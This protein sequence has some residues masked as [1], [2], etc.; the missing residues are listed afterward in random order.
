MGYGKMNKFKTRSI[1]KN[2]QGSISLWFA[3]LGLIMISIVSTMSSRYLTKR[4]MNEIQGT[5]DVAGV[6]A[7][8]SGVDANA[9]RDGELVV[10]SSHVYATF[11]E[12]VSLDDLKAIVGADKISF[13]Q[14]IRTRKTTDY[15]DGKERSEVYLVTNTYLSI[16]GDVRFDTHAITNLRYFDFFDNTEKSITMKGTSGDGRK[17]IIVRSVSRLV[18]R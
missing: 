9:W 3:I 1:V 13:T 18:L 2:T 11:K 8:R 4:A 10:D 12:L 7:L 14:E 15:T 5:I 16:P 6:A 17:E